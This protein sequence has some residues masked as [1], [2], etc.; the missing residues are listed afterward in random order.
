MAKK[1]IYQEWVAAGNDELTEKLSIIQYYAM[2]GLSLAEIATMI[3]IS[4]AA[5]TQLK[6]KY[7]LVNHAVQYK[8]EYVVALALE[9]ITEQAMAGKS[10]ALKYLL[11]TFCSESF[12]Q[13]RPSKKI[14]NRDNEPTNT[15]II[16]DLSMLSE[17]QIRN[18]VNLSATSPVKT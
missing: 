2:Q 15:E 18:L 11:K 1:D 6:R 9:K 13:D 3:G 17:E 14:V 5:L 4:E 8:K 10:W 7:P 12:R 16:F